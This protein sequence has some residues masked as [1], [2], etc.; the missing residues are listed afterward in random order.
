V[1]SAGSVFDVGFSQWL[2]LLEA[3]SPDLPGCSSLA[4]FK[5]A[6][7]RCW[8]HNQL[9]QSGAFVISLAAE[10]CRGGLA[11]VGNKVGKHQLQR[12]PVPSGHPTRRRSA[13]LIAC[14]DEV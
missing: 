12:A 13:Q 2:D 11:L 7:C 8:T 6:A 9:H 4:R 1:V 5:T 14:G 10:D 3:H